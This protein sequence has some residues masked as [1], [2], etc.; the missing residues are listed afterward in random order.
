[1]GFLRDSITVKGIAN[2][3]SISTAAENANQGQ[4]PRGEG[5][6]KSRDFAILTRFG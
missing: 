2:F 6:G 4:Q 5:L 1:L 3:I